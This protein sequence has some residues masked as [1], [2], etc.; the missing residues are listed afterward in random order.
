LAGGGILGQ[1]S[2]LESELLGHRAENPPNGTQLSP[3]GRKRILNSR[4]IRPVNEEHEGRRL[5]LDWSLG[6]GFAGFC[7]G[8]GREK[9]NV[10]DGWLA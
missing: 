5:F 8:G 3:T 10:E 4:A 1:F 2:W 9:L 6:E 7:K